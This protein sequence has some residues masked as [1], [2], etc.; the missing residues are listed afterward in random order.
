[1]VSS[2]EQLM[3]VKFLKMAIFIPTPLHII[4]CHISDIPLPKMMSYNLYERLKL[5]GIQ[6]MFFETL[7]SMKNNLGISWV[8]IRTPVRRNNYYRFYRNCQ[9][10]T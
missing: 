9:C 1:M 10:L 8:F 5:Q 7:D 3:L 2:R 6:V 4:F